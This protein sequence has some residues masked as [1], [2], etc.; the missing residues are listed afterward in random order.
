MRVP[1]TSTRKENGLQDCL[2]AS[3]AISLALP[4]SAVPK[5][6]WTVFARRTGLYTTELD[7]GLPAR[8]VG[9]EVTLVEPDIGRGKAERN[10]APH[11]LSGAKRNDLGTMWL[12]VKTVVLRP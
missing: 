4:R 2:R 3:L 1:E 9:C 7:S 6:G 8:G 5:A 12:C 10:A 11:A